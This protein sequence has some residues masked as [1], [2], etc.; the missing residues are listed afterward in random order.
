MVQLNPT[1]T[2]R[3]KVLEAKTAQERTAA[4]ETELTNLQNKQHS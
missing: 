2:A 1:E 3:L 4:E